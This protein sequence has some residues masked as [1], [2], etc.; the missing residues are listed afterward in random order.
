M[1]NVLKTV[2]PVLRS[3]SSHFS[4]LLQ[5]LEK[6]IF[7]VIYKHLSLDVV[8]KVTFQSKQVFSVLL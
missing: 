4:L 8:K 1:S 6:F 3:S 7:T 2:I 5:N